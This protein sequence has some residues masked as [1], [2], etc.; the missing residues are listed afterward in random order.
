MSEPTPSS[1][2]APS[3][4]DDPSGSLEAATWAL[5]ALIATLED[6][7]TK[8]PADVLAANPQRTAVLEAAGLIQRDGDTPALHPA[9]RYPDGA[10]HHGAAQARLSS[11]R[12]AL[13]VAAGDQGGTGGWVDLDDEVLLNQGRASAGTGRAI[14]G[15]LVPVL[16]GLADRLAA[17]GSRILDVGTGTAALALALAEAFPR[18][19]VVGVDVMERVLE[20]ARNELAD[21]GT[22]AAGRVTLRRTDAA[23]LTEQAAYDMIW[24]PAPFLAE[25]ALAQ[26]LPRL[27]EALKPGAWIVVGT[28]PPA[29]DPLRRAVAGWQAVRNGGNAYDTDRM[30]RTLTAHGLRDE[31]QFPTMPGGPVLVVAR[32]D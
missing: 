23:D 32:R 11:L 12:Q 18:A 8:A 26:A 2:P 17:Q 25:E 6:A 16:P 20:L 14:A 22:E 24:L 9:Y 30:T 5:A 7:A 28:N 10:T 19:E 1:V 27:T 3:P 21:A 29:P 13:A 31:R 15:R 4:D